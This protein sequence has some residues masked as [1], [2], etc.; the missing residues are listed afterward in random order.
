MYSF[1][2]QVY[3][4]SSIIDEIQAFPP[5]TANQV[6]W[7]KILS[8]NVQFYCAAFRCSLN[9]CPI[10]ICTVSIH[11]YKHDSAN[12]N[13]QKLFCDIL[14]IVG[15]T[16]NGNTD[17]GNGNFSGFLGREKTP[18]QEGFRE[19]KRRQQWL[20]IMQRCTHI[21]HYNVHSADMVSRNCHSIA[22]HKGSSKK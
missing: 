14:K 6:N 18:H 9:K 12:E 19:G 1:F 2:V 20:F 17:R 4:F 10:Q 16:R 5:P 21:W 11:G 8:Q 13:V 3:C 7:G 15:E 22:S